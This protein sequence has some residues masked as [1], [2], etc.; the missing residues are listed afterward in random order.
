[1]SVAR[2][3]NFNEPGYSERGLLGFHCAAFD[4]CHALCMNEPE[5]DLEGCWLLVDS[6]PASK[7]LEIQISPP[8]LIA[9]RSQGQREIG[10]HTLVLETPV[11]TSLLDTRQFAIYYDPQNIVAFEAIEGTENG[12]SIFGS[13]GYY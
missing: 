5:M 8:L 7:V 13:I 9:D 1:M 10:Q 12:K 6:K 2:G 4:S 3:D 11:F